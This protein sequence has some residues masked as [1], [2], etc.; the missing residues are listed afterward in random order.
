MVTQRKILVTGGA[1]FLGSHLVNR[2]VKLNNT[3]IVFDDVLPSSRGGINLTGA[4]FI[5][6][7]I[8]R[9]GDI[10][11]LVKMNFDILFHIA[12]SASVP[13]SVQ[14]PEA[15]FFSNALGTLKML[16]LAK[17]K[18]VKKFIFPSSVS[19]FD[20]QNKMPLTENAKIK[21]SSPYG[22][23]KL[24]GES[25]CYAFHRCYRLNT[26]VIRLF[27]VYGPG[28]NK[29]VIYDIVSKLRN[30]PKKIEIMGDGNQVR[31]Y[32]YIE[33]TIDAFLLIAEKGLP[34]EDYNVSSGKPTKIINL[35]FKI[36]ETM[37]IDDLKIK[38]TNRSWPGDIKEWCAGISKIKRLGF[39]VKMSLDEGLKKTVNWIL[40]NG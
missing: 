15:D 6:G 29:Y 7:S 23:S 35:V 24:A 36:A 37:G 18:N 16:K 1:G 10:E 8:F 34:G 28:M 3:V 11:R 2:L 39:K 19:I 9:N 38:P 25:Y 5:Q 20:N 22:A 33:D 4:E 17:E 13:K 14:D 31:D 30:N 27:N 21:V 26:N 12:A 32:L 40:E